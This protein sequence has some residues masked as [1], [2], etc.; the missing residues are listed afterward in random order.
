MN[1]VTCRILFLVVLG[2]FS[3]ELPASE[4]TWTYVVPSEGQQLGLPGWR[5]LPRSDH[6]PADIN[7]QVSYQGARQSYVQIRYGQSDIAR[8]AMVL[9]HASNGKITFYADVNRNR[10]IEPDERQTTR[11]GLW[12]IAFSISTDSQEKYMLACRFSQMLDTLS[13]AT[14]GDVQ[15]K[16]A[17]GAK[18]ISARRVDADANGQFA[19]E[20]DRIWLDLNEDG[21]WDALKEQFTVRPIL[22]LPSGRYAVSAD[23]MGRSLVFKKLEGTGLLVLAP[24]TQDKTTRIQSITTSLVSE[25]GG[26]FALRGSGS[27]LSVPVGRYRLY[28]LVVV[29]RSGDLG[30]A[31]EYV[32][33]HEGGRPFRWFDLKRGNRLQINPLDHLDLIAE[34]LSETCQPGQML[35]VKPVVFTSDGLRMNACTVSATGQEATQAHVVLRDSKGERLITQKSGFA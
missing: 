27:E 35:P 5:I 12:H 21:Q 23:R 15:G 6:C 17:I 7:E 32:F 9:D 30:Q 1:T 2:I 31:W 29:A 26:A 20:Q 14:Q 24:T 25:D 22:T 10:K 4:S 16:V 8:V 33:N 18:R 13:I 19:D 3:V 34:G 11:N 28:S